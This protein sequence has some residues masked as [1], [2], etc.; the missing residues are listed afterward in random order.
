MPSG[1][2]DVGSYVAGLLRDHAG[3]TA[4]PFATVD[5][6][7]GQLVGATRFLNVEF[8]TW[9]AGSPYQRGAEV[10]DVV[11]IGGTW[12]APSAQ[13]TGSTRRRSS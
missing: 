12:L 13:R 7:T 2:T 11:E 1:E 8:W 9:P 4:L 6:A 10:P 5:R 3:G